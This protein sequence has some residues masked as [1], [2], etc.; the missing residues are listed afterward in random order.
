MVTSCHISPSSTRISGRTFIVD[1]PV[2][3]DIGFSDHLVYFLVSELLPQVSHHVT[4]LGRT[5]VP[6]AVLTEIQGV[7]LSNTT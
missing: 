2:A 6:V 1:L 7:S 3:V 4:Q 5:D